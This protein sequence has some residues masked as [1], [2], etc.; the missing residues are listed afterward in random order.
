MQKK[1]MIGICLKVLVATALIIA[2]GISANPVAV[3]AE[4][5][6]DIYFRL[7]AD[8]DTAGTQATK[9][10]DV[11]K[12]FVVA[13]HVDLDT[14]QALGAEI[15]V[16]YDSNYLEVTNLARENVSGWSMV[17]V[18][19][20]YN[21]GSALAE[22]IGWNGGYIKVTNS[23]TTLKSGNI[24]MAEIT[25]RS[26]AETAATEVGY[27]V[28]D[29]L[30][31]KVGNE[32]AATYTRN[33]E[34]FT[35]SI[36]APSTTMGGGGG[37]GIR[38]VR[39]DGLTYGA[40]SLRIE[41]SGIAQR[42]CR[43]TSLDGAVSLSI[44]EGTYLLNSEGQVLDSLSVTK[45]TSPS[46][47]P[48]SA[49]ASAYDFGPDGA[50][51]EPAI[52]LTMSY[53]D[54]ALPEEAREDELYIAYWDGSQWQSLESTVDTES[55]IV[56]TKVSHFTHFAIIGELAPLAE[57]EAGA[58]S[59]SAVSIS[60]AEINI[61]EEVTLSVTVTNTGAQ[62]DSH[63][64][65]LKIEG[66]VVDTAEITLD[67]G[68]SGTVTFTTTKDVAGTYTANINGKTDTFVV[69]E[70][71]AGAFSLSAVSISPAE[72][73]IGEE[74]TLSV[75]VTNTGAQSDSHELTLKIEG[76]VVDTAEITLDAGASGTVTFTTT[77]D[78]AGT[79][80][81]TIDGLTGTFEVLEEIE[82]P[83]VISV[84]PPWLIPVIIAAV[85][86][87]IVVPLVIRWRR[88]KA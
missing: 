61:G 24:H 35:V 10:T 36:D 42:D 3:V 76:A 22:G 37:G 65:T 25:F 18:A 63:E 9:S 51:F 60:P 57:Q 81:V 15:Y 30:E 12:T 70:Q 19:E 14:I 78:V 28:T 47:K 86:T 11:G 80:S 40:S 55:H 64:L 33:Y 58:F 1:R 34:G 32:E 74:V 67:A 48:G 53:D 49:I 62:S 59:L 84:R 2:V 39:L 4:E 43:V 20:T 8:P 79:Y 26:K 52:S 71:E 77:K 46:P 5:P 75:T 16:K 21:D 7:D 31:T 44:G 83:P 50:T 68:A 88:M 82:A 54:G 23:G 29:P 41:E 13:L 6:V 38:Y 56:Q 73:N 27:L 85:T 66:A 69:K 87:A 45:V 17:K 72:I